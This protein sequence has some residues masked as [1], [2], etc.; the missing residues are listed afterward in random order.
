MGGKGAS[1]LTTAR[2]RLIASFI[3][4]FIFYCVFL[5]FREYILIKL[6]LISRL[7]FFSLLSASI[8]VGDG[9][10][11][12]ETTSSGAA[13]LSFSRWLCFLELL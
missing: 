6:W 1:W 3:Y 8:V 7:F 5:P 2:D 13:T 4:F 12:R 11:P 10:G 9:D